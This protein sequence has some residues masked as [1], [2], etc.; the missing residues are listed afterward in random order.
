MLLYFKI[1]LIKVSYFSSEAQRDVQNLQNDYERQKLDDL[2]SFVI[3]HNPKPQGYNDYI[4]EIVS[5][6]S[7]FQFKINGQKVHLII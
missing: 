6:R 5:I 2:E 1:P 7:N 4:D 3:V